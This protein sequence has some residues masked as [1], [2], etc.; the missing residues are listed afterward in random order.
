LRDPGHVR[1]PLFKLGICAELERFEAMRLSD[2][3]PRDFFDFERSSKSSHIPLSQ[4]RACDLSEEF[5]AAAI[6]VRDP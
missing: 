6:A 4:T 1:D 3:A 5:L 2:A